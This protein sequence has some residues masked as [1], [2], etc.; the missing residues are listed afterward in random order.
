MSAPVHVNLLNF[1]YGVGNTPAVCLTE[2]L[3]REE[4][5]DVLLLGCGDAR[6][7]LCTIDSRGQRGTLFL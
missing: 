1:L 5:V 4:D 2:G 7:I 3:P 6:N